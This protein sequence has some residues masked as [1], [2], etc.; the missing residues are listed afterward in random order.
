MPETL[1]KTP[2]LAPEVLENEPAAVLGKRHGTVR[3]DE[4]GASIVSLVGI[5]G[6]IAT[7]PE[8]ENGYAPK[9]YA[10]EHRRHGT[11]WVLGA[12]AFECLG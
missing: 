11:Q 1:P 2:Y 5:E 12:P 9:R 3:F 6:V 4:Y 7:E 8:T 10:L